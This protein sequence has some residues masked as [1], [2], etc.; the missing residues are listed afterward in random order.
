MHMMLKTLKNRIHKRN[1]Q[2][3]RTAPQ[4]TTG[5]KPSGGRSGAGGS[6]TSPIGTL[7]KKPPIP[8]LTQENLQLYYSE[9][10]PAFKDVQV[11]ERQNLFVQKLHLCS[12]TFN[13]N[14]ATADVQQK[15]TKRR[16][17]CEL[18][19]YVTAGQ[20]KFNEQIAEDVI[21]MVAKN[22]FRTLPPPCQRSVDT[23]FDG[24]E[25]EVEPYLDPAWPHLQLVYEFLLRY[26]VSNE[27]DTKV[28]RKFVDQRFILRLLELFDCE[29][30]RERDYLKAIV[31]RIYGKFMVYRHFIRR[32]INNIFYTFVFETDQ[33]N[34]IAELLE[35]LGSIINGFA[36]PLKDEHK[37]FLKRALLPLHK[38]K[39][40][41][42]YQ[43]QLAYCVSQFVE[44]D[45]TLAEPI[46]RALL[47]YWP[48][49][50]SSKEVYFVNE[51]EEILELT[52]VGEFVNVLD[53]LFKQI[54][55]SIQSAHFQVAER[56]LLIW[57]NEYFIELVSQYRKDIFPML[58][59]SLEE[60]AAGHWNSAVHQLT[61]NVMKLLQDL[62]DNLYEFCRQQLIAKRKKKAA[63]E[64][65]RAK[66]WA[67]I[68]RQAD[69]RRQQIAAMH[70]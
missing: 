60:N 15:E 63:K 7:D 22:L 27:T 12:F 51:L 38:P 59:E 10:L 69:Q 31:H 66:E 30:P 43:Q 3:G 19:D 25:G 68:E 24:G 50:N 11:T 23:S 5:T 58:I 17:L 34:G 49:T 64:Q 48:V 8:E 32:A 45:V 6:R 41:M 65:L 4:P 21:F 1:D 28:A 39:N 2:D 55:K 37:T 35:I 16:T 9:P 47:R 70:A 33:H 54:A 18:V 36:L 14:E 26:V 40:M 42:A 20:G 57:N 56:T 46:L 44:K 61:L 52:Q 29:D 53:I 62:D 67:I 13:F